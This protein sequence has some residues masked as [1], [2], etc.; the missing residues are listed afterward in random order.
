MEY[1]PSQRIT[2]IYVPQMLRQRVGNATRLDAM[3]TKIY[4]ARMVP[5][6][7]E[8]RKILTTEWLSATTAISGLFC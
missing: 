1:V 5:A 4:S 7:L 2:L 8:I 3:K 6:I